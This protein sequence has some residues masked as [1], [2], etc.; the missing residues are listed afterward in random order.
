M[1]SPVILVTTGI[2]HNENDQP[3]YQPRNTYFNALRR[4][5]AY[6]V[7]LPPLPD[8]GSVRRLLNGVDGLLVTGGGDIDPD[9]YGE[10]RNTRCGPS[11]IDR[12][13]TEITAVQIAIEL[14]IPVFGIC[15]GH[16]VLN[17]A[18]G[19][20]L[21]QDIPSQVENSIVHCEENNRKPLHSVSIADGTILS[22]IQNEN[23]I[24]VNSIHHQGVNKPGNGLR[25]SAISRD[26]VAEAIES[27]DGR[28]ILSV[29]W[30]PEEYTAEYPQFGKLFDWFVDE[31]ART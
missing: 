31:A 7:I 2:M 3:V 13:R 28:P 17:V 22:K 5:G 25:V 29:Q 16:Q 10:S 18:L 9:F 8:T 4:S 14:G 1:P 26:G 11:D 27:V 19:G 24:M 21:I 15:R 20:T 12:D 23:A 6:S 30:H